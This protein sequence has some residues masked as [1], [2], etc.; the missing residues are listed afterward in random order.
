MAWCDSVNHGGAGEKGQGGVQPFT[1]RTGF[2]PIWAVRGRV[3]WINV[4][5]DTGHKADPEYFDL[6]VEAGSR[7][8]VAASGLFGGM[9]GNL[10]ARSDPY[11]IPR[12]AVHCAG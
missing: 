10:A 8:A 6:P 11:Y 9:D 7:R 12:N 1:Q 3:N 4:L 2:Q 5:A